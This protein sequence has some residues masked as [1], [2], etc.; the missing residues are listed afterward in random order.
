MRCIRTGRYIPT[1]THTQ[2]GLRSG[3]RVQ[4]VTVPV[5]KEVITTSLYHQLK[6]GVRYVIKEQRSIRM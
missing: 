3:K 2:I 1:D 6:E 5:Y 4:W